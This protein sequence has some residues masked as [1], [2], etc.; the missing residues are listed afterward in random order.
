MRMSSCSLPNKNCDL[1]VFPAL[2][3]PLLFHGIFNRFGGVSHPP[4]NTR[5]VSFGLGDKPEHVRENRKRIKK[6]LGC[7]HLVSACQVH[8]PV[9]Y[10]VEKK[11]ADD[12]EVN[13]FDALVTNISGI[14][15]MIQ[16]ADCQAVMLLIL[17]KR[18]WLLCMQV[19]GAVWL[20]SFPGL[21]QP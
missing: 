15:L 9:V 7:A 1:L 17:K 2:T 18:L 11:P 14:G 8:G 10:I 6:N 12:L 19:G 16:Q 21:F 13:G 20:R 3:S 5:N 4:W